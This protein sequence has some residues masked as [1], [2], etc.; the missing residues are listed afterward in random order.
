MVANE[1]RDLNIQAAESGPGLIAC[2]S[3]AGLWWAKGPW[4]VIYGCRIVQYFRFTNWGK[5]QHYKKRSPPWIRL[6]NSL[7]R[8]RSFMGLTEAVRWHAVGLMLV[9]SQH[10]NVI[11]WDVRWLRLELKCKAAIDFTALFASGLIELCNEK[12]APDTSETDSSEADN[13]DKKR[14]AGKRPKKMSPKPDPLFDEFWQAYPERMPPS[15]RVSAEEQWT[16]RIKQGADPQDII[17]GARH[18][19]DERQRE[20]AIKTKFVK[21]ASTFLGPKK[22]WE[23]F[24]APIET[25][26]P[27]KTDHGIVNRTKEEYDAMPDGIR[28]IGT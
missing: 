5:Y 17:R 8:S 13:S 10:G 19:A 12:G 26:G 14:T 4:L 28:Q 6:H 18:Y 24:Q 21:M 20:N 9:A 15:N 3:L 16:A 1:S 2:L 25:T 22:H 11:E 23:Q 7:L 27:S